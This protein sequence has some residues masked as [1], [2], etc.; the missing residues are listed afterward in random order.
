MKNMN[1]RSKN[2]KGFTLVEVLV[3]LVLIGMTLPALTFRVQSILDNASYVDEKTLAYWVAENKYQEIL[4]ERKFEKEVKKKPIKKK[5][6]KQKDE[7]D[8]VKF[9]DIDWHILVEGEVFAQEEFEIENNL[10]ETITIKVGRAP[11]E[12]LVTLPGVFYD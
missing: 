1:A 12:W 9:A 8:E 11:G 6:G 4:L 5:K 10:I 7:K 3:A 2:N